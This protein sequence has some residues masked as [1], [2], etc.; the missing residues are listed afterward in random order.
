MTN[1]NVTQCDKLHASR[2]ENHQDRL[3]SVA[4]AVD[5]FAATH[6]HAR[7]R[8]ATAIAT[9]R[10]RLLLQSIDNLLPRGSPHPHNALAIASCALFEL[11]RKGVRPSRIGEMAFEAG[12]VVIAFAGVRIAVGPHMKCLLH[13]QTIPK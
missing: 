8:A 10:H 4:F 7:H 3:L 13:H 1:P 2:V 11:A 5:W 12:H 6:C 9:H